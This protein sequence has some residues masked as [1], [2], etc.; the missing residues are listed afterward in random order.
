MVMIATLDDFYDIW[1]TVL[2]V[3]FNNY[4]ERY[5][6]SKY[7]LKV[8]SVY[9][10]FQGTVQQLETILHDIRIQKYYIS[11]KLIIDICKEVIEN[12][13]TRYPIEIKY[14]YGDINI[15]NNNFKE[16]TYKEAET[17]LVLI[18][19]IFKKKQE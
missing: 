13:H 3:R 10:V 8:S 5:K 1:N 18:K 17:I 7:D 15:D 14:K 12:L 6:I 2:N 9:S 16:Y 4:I 11:I 19:D